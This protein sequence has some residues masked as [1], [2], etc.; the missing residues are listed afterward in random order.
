MA[1]EI[2]DWLRS[3]DGPNLPQ[4]EVGVDKNGKLFINTG[5]SNYTFSI[6]D[7]AGS[8]AG[9]A[10][11]PAKIEFDSNGNGLYDREFE[12]FS[13]FFGLNDFFV[14]N[15]SETVYDSK[16]MSRSVNL[17]LKDTVTL[18]FSNSS[19]GLNFGTITISPNDSLQDIVNSI[20]ENPGP[21]RTNQCRFGSQ[22]RRLYAADFKRFR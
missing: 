2:Q 9:T 11:Q 18:S 15:S 10:Q 3:A 6:I 8:A 7:E 20:N 16:V 4:A 21:E 19:S 12:G 1:Q 22:R 13:S 5:D 17:G 14:D